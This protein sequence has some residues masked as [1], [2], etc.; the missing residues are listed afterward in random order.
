MAAS[1]NRCTLIGNVG[2][3]P[4]IKRTAS[5]KP[6]A[7]IRLA[8]SD[9][10]TDKQ[11]GE[12]KER[13]DWHSVVIWN[14]GL[15]NVVEKYV[16]KGSKIFIE[17]ALQTRK[18]TDQAGVE[19]YTTEIVLQGFGGQ[20]ILLGGGSGETQAKPQSAPAQAPAARKPFPDDSIPF[21]M[22]R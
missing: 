21:M 13:T 3:D 2:A 9:Q 22:E 17:G 14:E 1:L 19:K 4:Q 20:L 7:N 12:V 18:W 8:T 11:S 10:W 5:G 15:C 16:R 6:V